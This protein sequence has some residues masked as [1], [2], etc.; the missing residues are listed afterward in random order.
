MKRG[1]YPK[2]SRMVA[3]VAAR[4]DLTSDRNP[5][6]SSVRMSFYCVAR[7]T[8]HRSCRQKKGRPARAAVSDERSWQ[9]IRGPIVRARHTSRGQG[10]ELVQNGYLLRGRLPT[11]LA[12]TGRGKAS[13]LKGVCRRPAAVWVP[14]V[15]Q[16]E[17]SRPRRRGCRRRPG[18]SWA[19][20]EHD[21]P[22]DFAAAS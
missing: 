8:P 11:D 18:P 13:S 7:L 2:R 10:P 6:S 15:F 5:A 9:S 19:I 12:Y 14:R 16:L 1:R 3:P 20:L 17:R 4:T 21:R 22:T